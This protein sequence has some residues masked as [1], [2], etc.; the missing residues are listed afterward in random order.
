MYSV[1]E[2]QGNLVK[3]F[4]ALTHRRRAPG[5][6]PPTLV[7]LAAITMILLFLLAGRQEAD[8]KAKIYEALDHVPTFK[9]A[10]CQFDS[11][12]ATRSN[13]AT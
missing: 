1:G 4:E 9:S 10:G 12:L 11:L 2:K 13:V 7:T 3:P 8:P 5:H 6:R